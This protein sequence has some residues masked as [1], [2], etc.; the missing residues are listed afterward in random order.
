MRHSHPRNPRQNNQETHLKHKTLHM[1]GN[2]H[3]DPVWLWTWQEG[4]HEVKASFR[5]ALDRMK[6]FPEFK[7]IASSAAFYEWVERSDP[8]MFAEIRARV[9]EGRWGL[10][11]GWWIEP[12]CNVPGGESFVRQ[13]LL[14]QRYFKSRFGVTARVGFNPD[15]FGHHA[16]LPQILK[17]SGL[18]YYAF[19]RPMPHEKS[20]PGRLFWW[21]S[22]DGSR[23]LTFRIPFEYLTWGREVDIHVARCAAEM[24]DP[25]DE[26]MCFYGVGNHGGGPTIENLESI[27]R[28]D[29]DEAQPRL[30]LST[31]EAFFDSVVDKGWNLPIAHTDL[32]HHASGCYA[33]H[34]GI[35]QWNR[36]AENRLMTAE[37][38]SAVAAWAAGQPYPE[39]LNQAWK[40]VLFNQFHDILAGT[41]LP[42]AYDDARDSYG[43]AMAIAGRALNYATQAV[44]WHIKT[45]QEAG[46]RPIVVFNPHAWPAKTNVELEFNRIPPTAALFDEIGA[47]VPV[48]S[49]QSTT[50]A[51]RGRL[52]FVAELPA[53]GYRTYHYFA[54]PAE[55]R[56]ASTVEPISANDSVLENDALR[57][58]FDP[59]TGC[60]AS[61]FDKRAGLQVFTGPAAVAQVIDDPS[62][63]W[64]HNVY[65]FDKVV[66]AFTA[67]SVRRVEHG[68]VKSVVRVISTYGGSRLVQ[69]FAMYR[70]LDR[71]E[72]SVT[73]DWH[74]R[75]KLLKLR[76]PVNVK[77]MKVT[78]EAPYGV[79]ED[80][81]NGDELPMQSWVDVSG[82]SRDNEARYGLSILND[83]KHSLDV[84]IRDVGLTVLRSPV[85]AHHIPDQPVP[86]RE[87]RFIDQGV[88]RFTYMLLPH[89]GS[90]EEAGTVRRA[91]ELNQAPTTLVGTYHPDGSLPPSASFLEVQPAN[92]VATV[93]KRAEDAADRPSATGDSPDLVLRVVETSRKATRATVTFP[94]WDRTFTLNL[95]PA[96]IKTIRIARDSAQPVIE[97]NLLEWIE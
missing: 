87:Y 63:T 26:F 43:E 33:A 10:V 27:K 72:V 89:A 96:E 65:R 22:D 7:F 17:K 18:P 2:A 11:G 62:D 51:G 74:E 90:W 54:T 44:A 76:F 71:I 53:L 93:L 31:P 15:S 16:M 55:G 59:T 21:E 69:D 77:F 9:A 67:E 61:L 37:K 82:T 48:Q 12:D 4:F 29:A 52:S 80:F 86:E 5:S 70:E 66:G 47:P 84:Y 97:T 49:V 45:P 23:V 91:A 24:Q 95:G 13:G 58:E 6:E 94:Q 57:L 68:P 83:G 34:S 88:Q 81:A 1:I 25:V 14:G 42:E 35:K 20:L 38:W 3:I 64:S 28:L 19:M 32:Q 40:A 60:I 56:T 78:R 92:V 75:F 36:K 85:Y 41:S 79:I 46:L 73:V 39:D 50:T 30:I 8:E